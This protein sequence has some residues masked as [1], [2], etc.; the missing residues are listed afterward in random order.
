M[1][2]LSKEPTMSRIKFATA[3]S[4]MW[5]VASGASAE[6]INFKSTSF[7][8]AANQSSFAYTAQDGTKVTAVASGSTGSKLYWDTEDGLGVYGGSGS[9]EGDEIDSNEAL[10]LNFSKST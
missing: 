1:L 10:T 7:S 3:L 9:Y 5:L 6:Y 2:S 8:A 4:F